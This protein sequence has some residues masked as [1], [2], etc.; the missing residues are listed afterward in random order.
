MIEYKGYL[1]T[2][3][4]DPEEEE[5]HGRVVNLERDGITFV[6]SSVEELKREMAKSVDVYLDWCR[7]RGEEP[8]APFSG[9][10]VVR[11]TPDLYRAVVTAAARDGENVDGWV[12]KALQRAAGVS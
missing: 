3:E 12:A 9:T 8:E 11:G 2:F 4:Y 6:G 7:E 1:G 5:F 10:F